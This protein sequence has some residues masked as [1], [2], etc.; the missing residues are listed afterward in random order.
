MIRHQAVSEEREAIKR[1]I[2]PQQSQVSQAI[3][4]AGENDLS[5][6]AS[7]RNMMGNIHHDNARE[8]SHKKKVSEMECVAAGPEMFF[9][10]AFPDWEKIMG[11]VPSVPEF[12]ISEDPHRSLFGLNRY[13]YVSNHPVT[14]NDPL[15]LAETCTPNGEI[16]LTPWVP[17][18]TSKTPITGWTLTWSG[19]TG[20]PDT[21][22]GVP[23]ATLNCRW[24]RLVSTVQKS[25]ALSQ[26]WWVCE[27][28]LPCGK[29]YQIHK[30]AIQ[31]RT[32][33]SMS[34]DFDTTTT[35]ILTM[36]SDSDFLDDFYC[37]TLRQLR[38]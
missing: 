31:S 23:A 34:T 32:R 9:S 25:L 26:V 10:W 4:V 24:T 33:I 21:E 36:G 38:P 29:T 8:S 14:L 15:G 28:P 18:S 5:G 30:W 37:R 35:R 20:G 11:L 2:L 22:S 1:G 19:E 3:G 27:E 12:P 6:I 16:Q 7:L 13:K 17:Y